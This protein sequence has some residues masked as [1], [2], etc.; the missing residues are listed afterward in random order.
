MSFN[1]TTPQQNFMDPTRFELVTSS[2]QM[3]RSTIE[4]RAPHY[5]LLWNVKFYFVKLTFQ[6]RLIQ[7]KSGLLRGG[8]E[9]T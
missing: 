8:H 2:L 4:L 5:I 1:L 6:P 3:K 7:M 9:R